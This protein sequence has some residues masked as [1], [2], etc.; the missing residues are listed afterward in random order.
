MK[1]K[2]FNIVC[3][4]ITTVWGHLLIPVILGTIFWAI[5]GWWIAWEFF[6]WIVWIGAFLVIGWFLT[7]AAWVRYYW[8]IFK[9][10]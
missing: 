10:K 4:L 6:Y 5:H 3:L 7:I 9:P 1:E 2:F 8:D